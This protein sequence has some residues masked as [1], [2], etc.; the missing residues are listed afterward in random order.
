MVNS[1]YERTMNR[2]YERTGERL[3]DRTNERS[4]FWQHNDWTKIIW[5]ND[6]YGL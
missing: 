4:E 3:N 6:E 1:L 5:M 2:N